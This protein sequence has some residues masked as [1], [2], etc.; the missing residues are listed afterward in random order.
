MNSLSLYSVHK[1]GSGMNEFHLGVCVGAWICLRASFKT[2]ATKREKVASIKRTEQ[3]AFEDLTSVMYT[4]HTCVKWQR[5]NCLWTNLDML[6][7][8]LHFLTQNILHLVLSSLLCCFSLLTVF[9]FFL[10]Y[11]FTICYYFGKKTKYRSTISKSCKLK[12]WQPKIT[13]NLVVF[14]FF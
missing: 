1:E 9:F 10:F 14:L 12:T 7:T 5:S 3:F 11:F 4:L 6:R 2:Y 8:A 13:F